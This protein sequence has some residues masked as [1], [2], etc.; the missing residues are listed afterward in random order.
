MDVLHLGDEGIRSRSTEGSDGFCSWE[1]G[2]IIAIIDFEGAFTGGRV[3]TIVMS[4]CSQREPF[5]PVSLEVVDEHAKVF[6]DL[7]IDS[8]CLS[9]RLRVVRS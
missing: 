4:E 3:C 9:V 6:F 5:R 8:L 2:G 1:Y 7:L